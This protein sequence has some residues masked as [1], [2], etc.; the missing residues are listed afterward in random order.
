MEK[1]KKAKP[2]KASENKAKVVETKPPQLNHR[3]ALKYLDEIVSLAP[4][5]RQ[6]HVQ[7]QQALQ[8][9]SIGIAR[10]EQLEKEKAPNP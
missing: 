7:A 10:L 1:N 2:P 8:Q 9:L 5:S 6:G 3:L 4:V